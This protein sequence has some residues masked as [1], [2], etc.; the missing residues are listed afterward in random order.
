VIP[1]IL[2]A[3]TGTVERLDPHTSIPSWFIDQNGQQVIVCH[4]QSDGAWQEESTLWLRAHAGR[5]DTIYC[6]YPQRMRLNTKDQRIAGEHNHK[7]WCHFKRMSD[8]AMVVTITES[9]D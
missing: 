3:R 6:C 8:K 7:I 4:G 2:I 1:V 9:E 5:I